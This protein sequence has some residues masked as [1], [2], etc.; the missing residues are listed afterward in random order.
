MLSKSFKWRNGF[1]IQ[2]RTSII[3]I[4][5]HHSMISV[6]ILHEFTTC[7]R[8]I[9]METCRKSLPIL[10]AHEKNKIQRFV[11][12]DEC[13]FI[14]EFHHS[15]RWS[16]SRDVPQ[17]VKQQI[18][19]QN[20]MMTVIWG[21]DGFVDLTIEQHSYNTGYFLSYILEPLLPA[22]FPDGRKPYS[23]LLSLHLD[24][25]RVHPSKVSENFSLKIRLFEYPTA[26][27]S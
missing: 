14:L 16:V 25:C 19:T 12:G 17:K 7:L 13:W 27:Q 15:M 10:K 8:Q 6:K 1:T 4:R 18:G 20:S 23:R 3:Q 22:V 24:N 21:I 26:L 9:R 11:T 2:F 5:S